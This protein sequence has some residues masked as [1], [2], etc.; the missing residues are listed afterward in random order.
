MLDLLCFDGP[1]ERI[2][3]SSESVSQSQSK[4][5]FALRYLVIGKAVNVAPVT[6]PQQVSQMIDTA[7]LPSMEML[8]KWEREGR[9]YGGCFAGQPAGCLIIDAASNEE[10]DELLPMLPFWGLQEWEVTPL[11]SY[12]STAKR[13]REMSQRLRSVDQQRVE[14]AQ[15]R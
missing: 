5:V 3:R 10:L 15:K 14:E 13:I 11:A 9:I 7:I 6:Q 1:R 8:A 2:V 4:E 12:E